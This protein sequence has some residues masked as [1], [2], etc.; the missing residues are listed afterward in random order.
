M[1]PAETLIAALDLRP[2][3]REGGYYRETYRS[4]RQ[5]VECHNKS[6]CTAMYYLLTPD[7]CSLLHRLPSDEIYHFYSG[8]P[9][10]LLLLDDQG[11]RRVVLGPSLLDG[12]VP[13]LVVP[14]GTW[15]GS[16]LQPGGWHA[17]LGTTMAPG[18][19]FS[20]W[21][22]GNRAALSARF[23]EFAGLIARLTPE[24]E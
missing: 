16:L 15:Q 7:T 6:V 23:P 13:Q 17:L 21:E 4:P 9:V 10:E 14:A 8:D 3:P 5:V 18:F 24:A 11:G 12:Q 20:D 1:T 22:G 2:L 19:E